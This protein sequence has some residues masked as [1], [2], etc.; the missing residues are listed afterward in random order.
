MCM[1]T[2]DL[3]TKKGLKERGFAIPIV[4]AVIALVLIGLYFFGAFKNTPKPETIIKDDV[5]F[6]TTT[7]VATNTDLEIS[8]STKDIETSLDATSTKLII[9]KK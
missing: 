1:K 2:R 5:S 7:E 9:P 3:G 8:T 4:V 6:S